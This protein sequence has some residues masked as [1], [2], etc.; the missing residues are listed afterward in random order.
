MQD[1][2]I[3]QLLLQEGLITETELNQA[4]DKQKENA[5]QRLG[6]VLLAM[7]KID[8]ITLLRVL[9]RQQRTQYLTTKKLSELS[10]PDAILK[11]VPQNICEKYELF[12]VQ[13]KKGEKTLII[14][15][16]DPQNVEAIDEV[17]F[18][19]GIA[20]IKGLV[21]L[22]GSIQAAIKKWYKGDRSA[23]EMELEVDEGPAADMYPGQIQMD[24]SEPA[25]TP[26]EK[27]RDKIEIGEGKE[28][29]EGL[30][31]FRSMIVEE[32]E[33]EAHKE[34]PKE[35]EEIMLGS[36]PTMPRKEPK[37]IIEEMSDAEKAT[38]SPIKLEPV[39]EAQ[40]GGASQG[41][42]SGDSKR[43][44]E[45]RYRRRMV[46]VE[47][48][49][50]V[51]KFITKL[52][53]SEGYQVRGF[54][55]LK[56]AYAE[57]DAAEYDSMVIKERYLDEPSAEFEE[58]FKK[59]Y[60]RLELCIIKDYGSAVI[61]ETRMNSRLTSSFLETL[62]VML[63]P[64][65][66]GRPRPPGALAQHRQVCPAD[67]QQAGAGAQGSGRHHPCGLY[68][69]PGQE[70]HEAQQHPPDRRHRGHHGACSSIQKSRSSFWEAPSSR[71]I[72]KTSCATSSSAGTDAAYPT[73]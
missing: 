4:L 73:A 70:G 15:T 60:P 32:D 1:R 29:D 50:Q 26:E 45:Q 62:D 69:R 18:V 34:E 58:H 33:E 11:L 64:F 35:D 68:S 61:G 30:V 31:D 67:R 41:Q 12:P 10:I 6:E 53:A 55:D 38:P 21:S 47:R 39:E 40:A 3:G 48:Q 23:F 16:S 65:G 36:K 43:A 5:D 72:S 20:S 49:E 8:E 46:L 42:T 17:R 44:F 56:E 71:S 52:F 51:R 28:G 57:L 2:K 9:A 66:D 54:A 14:V 63:G 27:A 13:Y 19:S 22:S 59:R 24:M 37:L 25:E 7:E